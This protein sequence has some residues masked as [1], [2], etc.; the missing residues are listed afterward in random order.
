MS[1]AALPVADGFNRMAIV[2]AACAV[3]AVAAFLLAGVSVVA[4]FAVGAGHVAVSQIKERGG[5]GL[6]VAAVSLAVGYL[7]AVFAILFLILSLTGLLHM[8]S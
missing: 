5:R 8:G 4:V 6:Q 2:S 1:A 7:I 3:V